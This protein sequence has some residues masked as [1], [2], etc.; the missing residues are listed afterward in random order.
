MHYPA[1]LKPAKVRQNKTSAYEPGNLL[2]Y[3]VHIRQQQHGP[4]L[5]TTMSM[6][7]DDDL[8]EQLE[9]LAAEAI[10]EFIALNG[11]QPDPG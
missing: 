11:W 8:K 4:L 6:R 3:C 1:G 9:Q 10:R 5:S 2:C 7:R